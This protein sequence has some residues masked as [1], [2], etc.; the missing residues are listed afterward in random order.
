[1]D[2]V[3]DGFPV[4]PIR[5]SAFGIS[6][7]LIRHLAFCRYIASQL[8]IFAFRQNR[9]ILWIRYDI[10]PLSLRTKGPHKASFV[11]RGGAKTQPEFPACRKWSIVACASTNRAVGI[12]IHEGKYRKSRRDLYRCERKALTYWHSA[13]CIRHSALIKMSPSATI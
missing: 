7:F 12:S 1:M 6:A 4:P 13:F 11:G 10:N 3:G 9:Y 2:F 8:D 5:H